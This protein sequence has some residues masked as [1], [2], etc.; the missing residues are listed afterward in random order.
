MA[1]ERVA[2]NG[3]S[4]HMPRVQNV[5]QVH[6][7]SV[8]Q[9]H[10]LHSLPVRH[11]LSNATVSF[12]SSCSTRFSVLPP[13]AR[14]V[15]PNFFSTSASSPSVSPRSRAGVSPA[16]PHPPKC[17]QRQKAGAACQRAAPSSLLRL[18][19]RGS[20]LAGKKSQSQNGAWPDRLLA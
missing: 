18:R 6:T 20:G 16:R 17:T 10:L 11:E 12:C 3:I 5:T 8:S 2:K 4:E 14:L 15:F 1:F 13:A 19:R 9:I 7:I